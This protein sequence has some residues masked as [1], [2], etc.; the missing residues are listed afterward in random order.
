MLQLLDHCFLQWEFLS[1]L[2]MVTNIYIMWSCCV[3]V[4]F[5]WRVLISLSC[6]CLHSKFATSAKK[7]KKIL[8]LR[9]VLGFILGLG[10]EVHGFTLGEGGGG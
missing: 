7:N 3:F 2:F 8:R 4:H 1:W 6:L 5:E 9:E 10:L